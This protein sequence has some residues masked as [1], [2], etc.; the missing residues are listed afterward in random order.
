MEYNGLNHNGKFTN[1]Y[2]YPINN[3]NRLEVTPNLL[4]RLPTN[5]INYNKGLPFSRE[6]VPSFSTQTRQ[7]YKT[8]VYGSKG[9]PEQMAFYSEN[10]RN[11]NYYSYPQIPF[12]RPNIQY[13]A[14]TAPYYANMV[15]GE[16]LGFIRSN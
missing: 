14:T 6:I 12:H 11:S 4:N 7:P 8:G 1:L 10:Y 2:Q 3:I 15:D 16:R 9:S 13:M 5:S